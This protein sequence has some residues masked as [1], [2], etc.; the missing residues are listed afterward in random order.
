MR[1]PAAQRL[2]VG[3]NAKAEEIASIGLTGTCK[4]IVGHTLKEGPLYICS[5]MDP[6]M[7]GL[8]DL[9]Q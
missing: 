6:W 8:G 5:R 1:K 9:D 4:K 3:V 7:V 2:I